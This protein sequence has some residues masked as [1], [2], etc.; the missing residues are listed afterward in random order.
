MSYFRTAFF[1]LKWL[2][3]L[4][5]NIFRKSKIDYT[6]RFAKGCRFDRC[7]IGKYSYVGIGSLLNSTDIGNYCSIGANVHIGGADHCYSWYTTSA[8]ISKKVTANKRTKIGNDVWIGTGCI[9]KQGINIGNSCVIGANSFV[10]KD[11][12]ENSIAF[13][14]PAKVWKKRF[15]DDVFNKLCVSKYWDYPPKI[16]HSILTEIYKELHV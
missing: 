15:A 5:I 9:I 8:R 11:I 10:N 7:N 1:L 2:I 12:P 3:F 16:A 13:G 4:P 6:A 14:S